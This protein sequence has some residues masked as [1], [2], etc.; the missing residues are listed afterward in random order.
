MTG[1]ALT[2]EQY[3]RAWHALQQVAWDQGHFEGVPA[4]AGR[5]M[6]LAEGHPL[7]AQLEAAIRSQAEVREFA[8]STTD[9]DETISLRNQWYSPRL[10][11]HVFIYNEAGCVRWCLSE[12][13]DMDGHHRL[14]LAMET[15]VCGTEWDLDAEFAALTRLKQATTDH[16]FKLYMLTGTF[17][18][19]SK[20]SGAF[21]VFRRLRPTLV[22]KEWHGRMNFLAALCLH[23]LGYHDDTFAGAMVP[24]DDV[25]AHLWLMRGDEHLFWR[26]SN[27]HQLFEREAGV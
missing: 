23:P 16:Q 26:R 5:T 9:V 6:T 3:D 19:T 24:T 1:P 18:E 7:K 25:L 2:R 22:L 12:P 17:G 20:A 15:I 11:R 8:C 21:Y 27:Q 13:F 10:R 4:P 14:R